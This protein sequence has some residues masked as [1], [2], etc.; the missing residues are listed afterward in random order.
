MTFLRRSCCSTLPQGFVRIRHL[1]FFQLR[2]A[3]SCHFAFDYST[4]SSHRDPNQSFAGYAAPPTLALSP[5]GGH[6]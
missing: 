3:L 6:A 5:S 1:A 2:R 4:Q